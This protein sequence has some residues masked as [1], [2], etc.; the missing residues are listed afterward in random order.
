[1][2]ERPK[3]T[4]EAEEQPE[5]VGR[6]N[7]LAKLTR[8]LA[9]GGTAGVIT[10][11]IGLVASLGAEGHDAELIM[12]FNT[13]LSFVSANMVYIASKISIYTELEASQY[14]I[15]YFNPL[16]QKVRVIDGKTQLF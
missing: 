2:F 16:E 4:T 13:G 11:V 5:W 9:L 6:I 3:K 1:M 12:A 7:K 15:N 10:G 8:S 14:G